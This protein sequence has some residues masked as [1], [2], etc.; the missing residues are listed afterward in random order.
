MRKVVLT[1]EENKCLRECLKTIEGI[2]DGKGLSI[3][4][5]TSTRTAVKKEPTKK[6]R[7]R[8]YAEL[9]DSKGKYQKPK[10]LRK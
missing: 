6:E 10:H 9:L 4:G 8:N 2:L 7:V 5:G 3:D 1:I